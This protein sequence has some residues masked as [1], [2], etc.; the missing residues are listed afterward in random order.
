MSTPRKSVRIG[1]TINPPPIPTMEPSAPAAMEA[2]NNVRKNSITI[3]WQR[4]PAYGFLIKPR[5]DWNFRFHEGRGAGKS[6][7]PGGREKNAY[8]LKGRVLL[9]T[10][11]SEG[12]YESGSWLV[13]PT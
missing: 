12:L 11:V 6:T 3:I 4:V 5:H 2:M 9:T 13:T 1:M 7:T 8:F 10:R